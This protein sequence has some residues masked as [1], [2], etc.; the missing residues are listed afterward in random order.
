MEGWVKLHRCML[1]WEWFKKPNMFRLFCYLIMKA[2]HQD[3]KWQ[4]IEIKRG[5]VLT[6]RKALSE[7]TGISEQS[8]RTCLTRLQKTGEINQQINQK[9]SLI[10]ILNYDKFQD[11]QEKSTSKSTTDQPDTNQI[12]TTNKNNKEE[13]EEKE[14]TN[15]R[16]RSCVNFDKFWE[17]YPKKTAKIAA[18]K[19]WVKMKCD[20]LIEKILV[21]VQSAK[22]TEGWMKE[23]G[24]YIPNPARWINEGRWEDEI[25]TASTPTEKKKGGYT[26]G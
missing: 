4:G 8:I 24:K 20:S 18:K 9:N 3:G 5:Q 22:T 1:E 6:G 15:G 10:T 11:V 2:N 21:S 17:V 14:T 7:A 19:A 23:N 12:L 16:S 26:F 13:E 25:E